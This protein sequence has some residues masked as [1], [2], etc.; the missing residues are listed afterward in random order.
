[1]PVADS[2]VSGG[3]R[4]DLRHVHH[5]RLDQQHQRP[6]PHQL[7]HPLPTRLR[8]RRRA[9][10]RSQAEGALRL[11]AREDGADGGGAE[12]VGRLKA[13]SSSTPISIELARR[14]GKGKNVKSF[15]AD[16][17][18]NLPPQGELASL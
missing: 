13:V 12:E 15:S 14:S 17:V 11:D 2:G 18:L 16:E 9:L 10:D 4:V 6:L 5:A 7:R 8:A 1:R 3:R